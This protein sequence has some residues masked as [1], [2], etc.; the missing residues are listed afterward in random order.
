MGTLDPT[1]QAMERE[2][3][4]RKG[5]RVGNKEPEPWPGTCCYSESVRAV[6][7]R[8]LGT[9]VIPALPGG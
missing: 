7:A 8:G 5:D 2:M 6:R 1:S 3:R 9:P 4:A